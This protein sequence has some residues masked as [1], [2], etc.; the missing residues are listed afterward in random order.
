MLKIAFNIFSTF[1]ENAL[2]NSRMGQFGTCVK[3]KYWIG[4][5][6][7]SEGVMATTSKFRKCHGIFS[8]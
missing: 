2:I 1:D 8:Q 6:K 3:F 4:W 7:S 5:N